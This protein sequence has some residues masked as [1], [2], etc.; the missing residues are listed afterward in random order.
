V[1]IEPTGPESFRVTIPRFI[2]I[3]FD[4]PVFEDP[5]ES[6]SA[7]SWLTP[8]AVQTRMINNILNDENKQ[9]YITQR[10]SA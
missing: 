8:P 1:K 10:S 5:L 4:D 9:K 6:N 2:G 7:P 3:G